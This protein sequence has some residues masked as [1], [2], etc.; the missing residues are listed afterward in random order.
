LFTLCYIY[1]DSNTLGLG[2]IERTILQRYF[3]EL[4]GAI[5][6]IDKLLDHLV[7]QNI[8]NINQKDEIKESTINREKVSKLLSIISNPLDFGHISGFY[9]MLKVM[10]I[11]GVSTTQ[12]LAH[13]ITAEVIQ[14]KS[15]H[16][17]GIISPDDIAAEVEKLKSQN[18]V[19]TTLTAIVHPIESQVQQGPETTD[20]S[21][22][23]DTIPEGLLKICIQTYISMIPYGGKLWWGK[24]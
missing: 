4:C 1:I 20:P 17:V 5:T 9:T 22:R 7:S 10:E 8:I 15:Q 18:F 3:A 6:D 16:D 21:L 14:L 12:C 2:S 19:N 11:H 24:I 23:T 13:N